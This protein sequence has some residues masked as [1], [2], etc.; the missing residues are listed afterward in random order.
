MAKLYRC[1]MMDIGLERCFMAEAGTVKD[2]VVEAWRANLAAEH[3]GEDVS[4]WEPDGLNVTT[5]TD[6]EL[7]K[8][9]PVP[10][11]TD[12]PLVIVDDDRMRCPC[13]FVVLVD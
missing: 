8:L 10:N 13:G 11:H 3:Q 6:P 7:K 9:K 2:A 5:Q 4:T 1:T 12:K